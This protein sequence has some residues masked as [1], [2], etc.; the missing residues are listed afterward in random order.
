[1]TLHPVWTAGQ[2]RRRRSTGGIGALAGL[3]ARQMGTTRSLDRQP[4][5]RQGRAAKSLGRPRFELPVPDGCSAVIAE[6]LR[7]A[8]TEFGCTPLD[9]MSVCSRRTFRFLTVA[10]RQHPHSAHSLVS[11]IV[12]RILSIASAPFTQ[13]VLVGLRLTRPTTEQETT[14]P[15][16]QVIPCRALKDAPI[17]RERP[18]RPGQFD[19]G[20]G[21][22]RHLSS[23]VNAQDGVPVV[24]R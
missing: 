15:V 6:S 5:Q 20:D 10:V 8:R 23:P 1:M 21:P 11:R 17:S 7:P 4:R 14:A 13:P 24:Q 22:I 18:N 16:I 2:R 3:V 9:L 19:A 12:S